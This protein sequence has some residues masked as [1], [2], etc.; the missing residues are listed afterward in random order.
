[1]AGFILTVYAFYVFC[2]ALLSS[3]QP[4]DETEFSLPRLLLIVTLLVFFYA[5]LY[6]TAQLYLHWKP[7]YDEEEGLTYKYVTVFL[8][9]HMLMILI[10][11]GAYSVSY[12]LE[13]VG[14]LQLIYIV[15]ML[16]N[17]PY[18]LKSQNVL[19]II[20]LFI[21]LLFTM[22]LIIDQY[23]SIPEKYMSYSVAVI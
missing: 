12:G 4:N 15:M 18:F 3:L 17:R 7:K 21:G 13:I 22:I 6:L 20:C 10:I 14:G 8:T 19:L 16:I 23:L 2:F 9:Y 5:T 1:M 11:I